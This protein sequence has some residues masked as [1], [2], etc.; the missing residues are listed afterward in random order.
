[1]WKDIYQ[2]VN[3]NPVKR[4]LRLFGLSLTG[5]MTV[6]T[7]I[8]YFLKKEFGALSTTTATLGIILLFSALICPG[9]LRWVFRIWMA[10]TMPIAYALQM[11]A[12]VLAYYVVICPVGLLFRIIGRD[13]L[14]RTFDSATSSYW[15]KHKMPDTLR[16]YFRQY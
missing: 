4:D 7:V 6:L 11:I 8:S 16:R 10:I 14:N 3:W 5:M 13:R 2:H 1:M 12:L 9:C 15:S